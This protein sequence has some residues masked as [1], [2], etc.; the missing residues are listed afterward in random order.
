MSLLVQDSVCAAGLTEFVL[1]RT[2]AAG[3]IV[4]VLM[5]TCA[6]GPTVFVLMCTC[7]AGLAV[8]EESVQPPGPGAEQLPPQEQRDHEPPDPA[9]H[10]SA[11]PAACTQADRTQVSPTSSKGGGRALCVGLVKDVVGL[12]VLAR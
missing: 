2:C 11:R 1:M 6:A 10:I 8:P 5:C 4:F 12:C 7:V 9:A 3:P